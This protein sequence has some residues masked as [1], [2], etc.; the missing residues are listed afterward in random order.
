MGILVIY[1]KTRAYI[2]I[3]MID[4]LIILCSNYKGEELI[5]T[6]FGSSF[7]LPSIKTLMQENFEPDIIQVK[8]ELKEQDLF[9]TI[10]CQALAASIC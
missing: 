1:L 4:S 9:P 5:K 2:I 7:P 8:E 3:I 6:D 10:L